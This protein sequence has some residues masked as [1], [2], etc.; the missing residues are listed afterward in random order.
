MKGKEVRGRRIRFDGERETESELKG[1]E[2]RET[3]W[4][5]REIE[6]LEKSRQ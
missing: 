1:E 5:M 6:N 2:R 3:K 4:K